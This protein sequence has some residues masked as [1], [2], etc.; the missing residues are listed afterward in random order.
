LFR[1]F[2][3]AIDICPY[4]CP[5][6]STAGKQLNRVFKSMEG[7]QGQPGPGAASGILKRSLGMVEI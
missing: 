7:F 1:A 4:Y 6:I 2:Y 3:L 5:R